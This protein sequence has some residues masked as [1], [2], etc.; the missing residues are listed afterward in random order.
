MKLKD[1]VAIVVGGGS[2][3]ARASSK[4]LAQEGAKVMIADLNIEAANKVADDIKALGYEAATVK[5][6]MRKEEDANKMVKVTLE[7]Y[8]KIDILVNVA[9]GSVGNY[10]IDR[11][12][13]GLFAQSTKEKWDR[14][15]DSNINGARNCTRAAINHMI[16]NGSGKIVCFSS[17]AAVNGLV[18]GVD[19]SAAKAGIIGF[20]RSLA[21]EVEPHG[22]QVNCITP[23]GTLSERMLSGIEKRRQAGQEVDTSKFCTPEEVAEAVLFLVSHGSDHMSGHNIIFGTPGSP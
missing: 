15:F 16:E 9:G 11:E 23:V 19:Y 18:S 8:G 4:L 7:K 3:I 22:I 14:I 21:K 5:I 17:I 12:E 2:G 1:K 10:I 20:T 13:V 6:D